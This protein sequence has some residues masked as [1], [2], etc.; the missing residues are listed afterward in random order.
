MPAGIEIFFLAVDQ[1]CQQFVEPRFVIHVIPVNLH[2][3]GVMA[4][5]PEGAVIVV[6]I[7]NKR[8]GD[9][10]VIETM[11]GCRGQFCNQPGEAFEETCC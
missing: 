3:I 8:T 10:I 9:P 2:I 5:Q 1:F 4:G 7:V 6:A 11:A